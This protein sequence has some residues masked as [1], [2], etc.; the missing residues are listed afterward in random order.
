MPDSRR[1]FNL[2]FFAILSGFLLYASFPPHDLG[3][4]A[5]FCLAPLFFSILLSKRKI[6]VFV[7]AFSAGSLYT[8][9]HIRWLTEVPNFPLVGLV[10]IAAYTGLYF[11]AFFLVSVFIDR[12]TKLPRTLVYPAVFVAFEFM[13]SNMSFLAIPFGLLGHSQYKY[14]PIIQLASITSVYGVSFLLVAVNVAIAEICLFVSSNYP[15]L[16]LLQIKKDKHGWRLPAVIASGMI[17]VT[18]AY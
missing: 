17:V 7:Y 10:L 3:F 16:Q 8:A 5:W 1:P 6:I 12:K 13:R 14:L 11:G 15:A 18:V 4:F 2:F 9:L